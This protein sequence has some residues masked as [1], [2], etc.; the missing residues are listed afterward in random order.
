MKMEAKIEVYQ[1][2]KKR[3]KY[4]EVVQTQNKIIWERKMNLN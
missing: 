3:E 4:G 2:A 1:S